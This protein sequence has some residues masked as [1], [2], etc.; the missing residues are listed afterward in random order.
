M[1]V[2]VCP[3]ACVWSVCMQKCVFVSVANC[4]VIFGELISSA[5]TLGP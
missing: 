5:M 2:D 1:F 4:C 3:R